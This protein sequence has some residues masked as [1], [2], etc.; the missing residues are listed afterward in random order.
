MKEDC[1][2][3]KIVE[4]KEE[5]SIVYEDLHTLA[6]L[7][8]HPLNP[9][10]TLVIPKKHYTNMLE[11]PASEAGRVFESVAKVMKGVEKASHAD[12]ISVGQSNGRAA[13]QEVFHMHVHIIPRYNHEMMSG[14]PN[15]KQTHRAELNEIS[16]KIKKSIDAERT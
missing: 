4:K 14:F 16:K 15:R 5:A 10:H 1:V 3:C 7:D 13:S 9:G 6:F 2:F 12:G 11:M 8:I